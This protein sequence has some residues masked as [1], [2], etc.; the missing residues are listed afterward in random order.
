VL[1]GSFVV[2][3]GV[4]VFAWGTG[5]GLAILAFAFLTHVVS[6]VDAVRQSAF[7]GFGRWMPWISASGGLAVGI[8]APVLLVGSV[9]AWPAVVAGQAGPEGYLVNCWAYR[10]QGPRQGDWVWLRNSPWGRPRVARVVATAGQEVAWRGNG[11]RIDGSRD[12]AGSPFRAATPPD[13]LS[14][15][16]PAGH[17]M[18]DPTAASRRGR[19]SGRLVMVPRDQIAGQ[20]WARM[21]PLWEREMLH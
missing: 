6:A 3:L 4:S 16:V 21:Y 10:G 8:Y 14:Y 1:F 12:W 18:I 7:P 13:E 5:I 9:V 15:V 2:A 17:V 19:R 11:L 20:P